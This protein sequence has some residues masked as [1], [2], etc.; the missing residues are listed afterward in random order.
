MDNDDGASADIPPE[1]VEEIELALA[2]E[3][4]DAGLRRRLA[5]AL[6]ERA[7]NSLSLT[8]YQT[9]VMTTARQLRVC[10]EAANRIVALDTD[11]ELTRSA[12]ELLAEVAAGRRWTW[13]R[14]PLATALAAG[15]AIAGMAAVVF[16]ALAGNLVFVVLSALLSSAL[17]AVVIVRFRR[18][19]WRIAAERA[20]P[21]I[22]RHGI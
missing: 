1:T 15:S 14:Q 21:A 8:R 2:A 5:Q 17:L 3:P 11:P 10:E 18:E 12:G 22:W 16:A 19:Q 13:Q 6:Y 9:R 7:V 4:G 20:M